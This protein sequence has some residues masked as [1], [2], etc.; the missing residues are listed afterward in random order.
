MRQGRVPTLFVS[1]QE[2]LEGV[3]LRTLSK[4]STAKQKHYWR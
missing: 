2:G 3:L 1:V 4:P